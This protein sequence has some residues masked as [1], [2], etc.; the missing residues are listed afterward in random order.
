MTIRK[1]LPNKDGTSSEYH[2]VY[3]VEFDL[4]TGECTAVIASYRSE[5][6]SLLRNSPVEFTEIRCD[7]INPGEDTH[8]KVYG[9]LANDA[10]YADAVTISS[11]AIAG[12]AA[13][14]TPRPVKPEQPS[15]AYDWN[16]AGWSWVI[17]PA[18]MERYRSVAKQRINLAWKVAEKEPFPAFGK[19]FDAD[20]KA[21]QRILGA[22]QAASVAIQLG[23]PLSIEWTCA[24]N[25]SITLDANT[26][27][28]LPLLVAQVANDLHN[29]YLGLKSQLDSASTLDEIDS[30][31]W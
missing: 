28:T 18:G 25:S 8:T 12:Y 17:T 3:S 6:D 11:K 27:V 10:R 15:I 31:V 16:E 20:D 5:L 14:I 23:Q 7:G 19:L 30:I 22:A 24:D 1:I 29:R 21:I 2:A 13:P 4:S 9:V 26:L